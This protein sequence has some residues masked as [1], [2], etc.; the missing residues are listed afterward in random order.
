[1]KM[2]RLL[3]LVLFGSS[4]ALLGCAT[5]STTP[6]KS[7][8]ERPLIRCSTCGTE[9]TSSAGITEHLKSH[10][11]HVSAASDAGT[12][13]LIKCET[14]GVEFTAQA[15]I[16]EHIKTHPGHEAVKTGQLINCSTCGVEFT[17]GAGL[18]D[19]LVDHPDHKA[20]AE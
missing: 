14:C 20:P 4:L 12:K 5:T 18:T 7:S 8:A 15:G 11:G 13:P 3:A 19:H 9:F 2:K 10:P 1:M 17:S 6:T 16:V